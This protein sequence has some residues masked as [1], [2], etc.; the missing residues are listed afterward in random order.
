RVGGQRRKSH[1][2]LCGLSKEADGLVSTISSSEWTP[3]AI[4][5]EQTDQTPAPAPDHGLR[6]ELLPRHV[7]II[8]DGNGRWAQS[9]GLPRIERHCRGGK[10]VRLVIEECTRLGIEQ[11]TLYCLSSE[12]FKRPAQEL[13]LLM[14]LL[15]QYLVEERSEIMRQILQFAI[16]G[17]REGL[18]S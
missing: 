9:R 11:L 2:R 12:N 17:K 8:M 5:S 4:A 15:E 6:T 3:V 14:R 18:I 1:N 16:I 10:T 7:A 13:N